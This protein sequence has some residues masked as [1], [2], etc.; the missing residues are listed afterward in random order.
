[1]VDAVDLIQ[2]FRELVDADERGDV[3]DVAVLHLYHQLD[4]VGAAERARVLVVDLDERVV[5][6]QQLAEARLQLQLEA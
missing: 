3:E 2:L 5:L 1:V 6:R 4:V